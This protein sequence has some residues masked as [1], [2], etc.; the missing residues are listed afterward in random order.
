MVK[1]IE[2]CVLYWRRVKVKNKHDKWL[3]E[4]I[5]GSTDANWVDNNGHVNISNYISLLDK[6]LESL[7]SFPGSIDSILSNNVS[8]VARS[9]YVKHQRE[10]LHP[11]GWYMKAGITSIARNKFMSFHC[12]YQD[13]TRVAKF[14][15][16]SIFFDL[17]SRRSIDLSLEQIDLYTYGIVTGFDE[18]RIK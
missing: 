18:N 8:Y 1:S 15:L 5:R 9:Y 17:V 13:Q 11:S 2:D 6:S 12:L 14:Y 3:Q 7:C 4:T 10:L 16:E